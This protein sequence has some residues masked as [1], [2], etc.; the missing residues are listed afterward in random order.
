MAIRFELSFRTAFILRSDAVR[1]I[2]TIMQ[3]GIGRVSATARCADNARREFTTI[4]ALLGF[5]NTRGKEIRSLEIAGRSDDWNKSADITFRSSTE[6]ISISLSAPAEGDVSRLRD[7]L[8]DVVAGTKAW[9][10]GVSRINLGIVL[11]ATFG[12]LWVVAQIVAVGSTRTDPKPSVTVERAFVLA[13]DLVLVLAGF[14]LVCWLINHL[15]SRYFPRATFA[16]GQGVDRF[17]LDDKIRWVVLIG[18]FVSVFASLV[19]AFASGWI[20]A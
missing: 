2:W 7:D 13:A 1:R 11:M 12:F 10:S 5:D 4:D 8:S 15:H 18:F 6:P 16:L 17:E 20:K 9:Y 3:T 19:V 14:M